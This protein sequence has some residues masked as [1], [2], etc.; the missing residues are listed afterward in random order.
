MA[1]PMN[2]DLLTSK[3]VDTF[4]DRWMNDPGFPEQLRK[5]PRKVFLNMNLVP[6]EELIESLMKAGASLPF[7]ELKERISKGVNMQ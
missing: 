6:S 2:E 4:L 1:T 7:E 3:A 5:D